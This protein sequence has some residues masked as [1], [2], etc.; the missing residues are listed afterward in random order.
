MEPHFV[1][2]LDEHDNV[3]DGSEQH[4]KLGKSPSVADPS[5]RL[6]PFNGP[7]PKLK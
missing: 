1:E 3:Q 7:R 2:L 5:S 6:H 4:L